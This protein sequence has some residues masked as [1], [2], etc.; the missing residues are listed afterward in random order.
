MSFIEYAVDQ[1]KAYYEERVDK[2]IERNRKGDFHVCVT[3]NGKPVDKAKIRYH[4]KK[5]DFDFGC[6]IFMLGQY[7]DPK[8]EEVYLSQWKNLFNTAVVPL[9]WEGTEP[10]EGN[11]RYALETE[12]NVYRRPPV[13]KVVKYCQENDIQMKGH[14]LFWHEFIAKWL[15]EDWDSLY[16]LIE[17]RF[18]EISQR[19]ADVIPVF[20]AVNEPG[21]IWDMTHEHRWDHYKMITPPDGYLEQL[22]ALA[23]KYFPNNELILNEATGMAICEFKGIYGAYYQLLERLLKEGLKIDRIGLQCHVD[24]NAVF[25]NVFDPQRLYGVLDGYARLDRPMVLSEIGL[26]CE[27][28]EI[29]AKAAEQLYKV[30]FSHEKMSGIFWWNLDDNGILC[31]KERNALGENLPYGG[32]VRDGKPKKAYEV[33]D[34]LINHEWITKGEQKTANGEM[35]FRGFYGTYEITVDDGTGSKKVLADFGKQKEGKVTIEL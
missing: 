13:D 18:Q 30:C 12:D 15:P 25:Q 14:P 17:K 33:L 7:E 22:F 27:N 16:P 31:D 23:K 35:T 1:G 6:N 5:I 28:E 11:L 32:L 4:L 10:Q 20:D 3:K 8:K 26:S 2:D 19:Y 34:R 21:R 9:Y 24:D 29:Q